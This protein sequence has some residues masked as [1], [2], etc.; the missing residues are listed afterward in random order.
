MLSKSHSFNGLQ[1]QV[2]GH[3][4]SVFRQVERYAGT[5]H[6]DLKHSDDGIARGAEALVSNITSLAQVR[7]KDYDVGLAA[8]DGVNGADDDL[9]PLQQGLRAPHRRNIRGELNA[10]LH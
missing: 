6:A 4:A 8:L 2:G 5:G 10:A 9:R 3:D 7:E 1:R